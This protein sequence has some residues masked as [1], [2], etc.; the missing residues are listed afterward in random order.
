MWRAT[1][2]MKEAII[3]LISDQALIRHQYQRRM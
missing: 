1:A 2:A 3:A